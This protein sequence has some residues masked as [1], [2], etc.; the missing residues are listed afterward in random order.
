MRQLRLVRCDFCEGSG[1]AWTPVSSGIAWH[2]CVPCKGIGYMPV[3]YTEIRPLDGC[4]AGALPVLRRTTFPPE[5]G[6]ALAYGVRPFFC[7]ALT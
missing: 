1:Q 6:R 5:P 3:L 4:A 2:R 7:E